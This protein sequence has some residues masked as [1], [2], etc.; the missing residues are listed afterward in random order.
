MRLEVNHSIVIILN[1]VKTTS[2][3]E[4]QFDLI[5]EKNN[6]VT[7]RSGQN[8]AALLPLRWMAVKRGYHS[9]ICAKF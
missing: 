3:L 2:S 8:L 4:S 9:N 6:V 1:P 7:V 5:K